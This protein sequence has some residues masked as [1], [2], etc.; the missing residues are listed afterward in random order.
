LAAIA[1]TLPY[2]PLGA[3]DAYGLVEGRAM[4]DEASTATGTGTLALMPSDAGGVPLDPL[5]LTS[6]FLKLHFN[7]LKIATGTGFVVQHAQRLFLITAGHNLSG[8]DAETNDPMSDTGALPNEVRIGMRHTVP[9]RGWRMHREPLFDSDGMPRWIVHPRGQRVDV[10]A[11]ELTNLDI[12]FPPR[13][14][15]LSLSNGDVKLYPSMEVSVIGFPLG[16]RPGDLLF[17]IWKTGHIAS[18][19]EISYNNR[20]P[21]ILIDATTRKGMSGSPVF[22]RSVGPYLNRSRILQLGGGG[23]RFLGVYTGRLGELAELGIVWHPKTIVE[24]LDGGILASPDQW[25]GAEMTSSPIP[26]PER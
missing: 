21:A 2:V 13:V 3:L 25:A 22:A 18:E 16:L 5:S 10:A 9:H 15:D 4:S 23:L 19:P 20:D 24:L 14:L 26:H 7:K 12:D 6:L 1:E 11:L 17:P 8:R